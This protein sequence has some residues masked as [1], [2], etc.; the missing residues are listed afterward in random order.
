MRVGG[1]TVAS[2]SG[3]QQVR[4]PAG[5]LGM[6]LRL[7]DLLDAEVVEIRP[8]YAT[9]RV[10]GQLLAATL[11]T[12]LSVGQ[13][14]KL[15]VREVG[16]SRVT[17]QVLQPAIESVTRPFSDADVDGH[18]LNMGISPGDNAREAARGLVKEGL[19]LTKENLLS[20]L[21]SLSLSGSS[22]PRAISAA[23]FLMANDLPITS[24]TL[25]LAM[26]TDES[27]RQVGAMLQALAR[28]VMR[29]STRHVRD[30]AVE[31]E[32]TGGEAVPEEQARALLRIL[33]ELTAGDWK[34]DPVA[35]LRRAISEL[36][37][38]VEA[39]IWKHHGNPVEQEHSLSALLRQLSQT[40][41]APGEA[42]LL[43][44]TL[45]AIHLRNAGDPSG[46]PVQ[47][48]LLPVPLP[49][50]QTALLRVEG[51]PGGEGRRLR[52]SLLRLRLDVT[53]LN[54][55]DLSIVVTMI[56][57]HL[58]ARIHAGDDTA[59]AYISAGLRGLTDALT[60]F[61]YDVG[62]LEC[63]TRKVNDQDATSWPIL[64]K[65]DLEA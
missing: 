52:H 33:E 13:R 11:K 55:G 26:V 34:S 16:P 3:A 2:A 53:L 8:G 60:S 42:R 24:Q 27:F 17:L 65:L 63:V 28:A 51:W 48:L 57:R 45:D 5:T 58:I 9:L 22:S 44:E 37:T 31:A 6:V 23:V 14:I 41:D 62:K 36:G 56:G 49:L 15:L 50:G 1:N 43:Q 40:K 35:Q 30:E 12:Q 19:P 7:H 46:A 21:R 29:A 38:P 20:V 64:K 10:A 32:D 47:H 39:Q 18:L 61:G 4:V 25:N 54:L 59:R